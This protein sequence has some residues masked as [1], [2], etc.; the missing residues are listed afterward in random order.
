MPKALNK[1]KTLIYYF[2]GKLYLLEIPAKR[3]RQTYNQNL[4]FIEIELVLHNFSF[5]AKNEEWFGE[6]FFAKNGPRKNSRKIAVKNDQIWPKLTS[7]TA[8]FAKM[9]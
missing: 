5:F 8:S 9:K 1:N 2:Y 6:K 3:I 7:K 4:H